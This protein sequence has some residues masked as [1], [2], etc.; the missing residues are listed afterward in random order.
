MNDYYVQ[1]YDIT[2]KKNKTET[3]LFIFIAILRRSLPS[4]NEGHVITYA[5]FSRRGSSWGSE[6]HY[7]I[8]VNFTVTFFI[9]AHFQ[10]KMIFTCI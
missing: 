9:N 3:I 1:V 10:K 6:I 8:L 4:P 7:R 5:N 2:M